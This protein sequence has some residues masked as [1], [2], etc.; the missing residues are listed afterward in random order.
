MKRATIA[1]IVVC[2]A[3]LAA[4]PAEAGYHY[5]SR[6]WQEGENAA[7]EMA[8]DVESWVEGESAKV[9]FTSSGNPLMQ[10]GTYLVTTDGGQKLYLVNPKEKTY[11]EWDLSAMLG[12]ASAVL[13]GAQGV[14][15]LEITEPKVETLLEEDGGTVAGEPTT[16]Y[17]F[18][19]TYDL[20]MKILG[21]K[22]SQHVVQIQDLW[23]ADHL[24]NPAL[25]IWLKREPPDLGDSGLNELVKAEMSKL[26]GLPLRTVVEETSVDK[27]G[28][29]SVSRTITEVTEF[30]EAAVPATTFEIPA[31]YELVQIAPVTAE[32]QPQQEEEEPK[33]KRGLRGL[34]RG[35]G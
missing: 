6:T 24:D 16:H 1:L 13:K 18:R 25:G 20:H 21:M 15:N 32:G 8:M 22:R 10:E 19:T 27:K 5:K 23:A 2:L 30:G 17:R 28:R 31:D 35:D 29:Q 4:A 3:A 7:K 12:V 26:R 14:F 34:L 33:K 11:A 9:L